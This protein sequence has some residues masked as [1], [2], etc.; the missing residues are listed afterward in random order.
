MTNRKR[1]RD[2]DPVDESFQ[3]DSDR[4][5]KRARTSSPKMATFH[6]LT[7]DNVDDMSELDEESEDSE[8]SEDSDSEY[9]P[10]EDEEEEHEACKPHVPV[11]RIHN[12]TDDEVW[13]YLLGAYQTMR[14]RM[15]ALARLRQRTIN[16]EKEFQRGM[17]VAEAYSY[18]WK[19]KERTRS[20]RHPNGILMPSITFEQKGTYHRSLPTK[21]DIM[22][23]WLQEFSLFAS[24]SRRFTLRDRAIC[25]GKMH[26][27][28][29][30]L[31]QIYDRHARENVMPILTRERVCVIPW[32]LVKR[33]IRERGLQYIGSSREMIHFRDQVLRPV[34][35]AVYM[36]I[37]ANRVIPAPVTTR[38]SNTLA[39][40]GA[41]RV[42]R[43]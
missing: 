1:K 13:A 17:G 42:Q 9:E 8:D 21:G 16:Q 29:W 34:Y 24:N 30:F 7:A 11:H 33:E 28:W 18:L 38:L 19:T 26:G 36:Y 4:H 15:R 35:K 31:S 40:L 22:I 20:P 6:D 10:S 3:E 39:F 43:S 14:V 2:F 23:R 32:K 5:D 37:H 27:Y 41:R 12:L 25:A